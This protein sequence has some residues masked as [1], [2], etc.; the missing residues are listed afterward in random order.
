M[1]LWRDSLT[2]LGVSTERLPRV[3]EDME[4]FDLR[5]GKG[6]DPAPR[7][8]GA[9]VALAEG[10]RPSLR[11]LSALEAVSHV[12]ANVFRP[13]VGRLLG[14]EA[15][16]FAQAAAIAGSAPVYLFE[17]PRRFCDLTANVALIEEALAK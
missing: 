8:L 15:A 14:R 17:R 7:P 5:P 16:L 10:R 3:H 4:K 13:Y 1:K 9:L 2:A 12:K 6:F 11:R